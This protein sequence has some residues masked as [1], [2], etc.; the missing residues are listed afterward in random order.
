MSCFLI[1]PN[2]LFKK[3]YLIKKND[4][5]I[6]FI[7]EHPIFYGFRS[8]KMIFN[9]KKLLLHRASIQYYSDYLTSLQIKNKIIDFNNINNFD[10][11]DE[12]DCINF[13]EPEDHMLKSDIM[14]YISSNNKNFNVYHNKLFLNS[15]QDLY[16]YQN[17]TNSKNS[18]FHK[19]FYDWQLKKHKIPYID[20]SY[21]ELNRNKLPDNINFPNYN[22]KFSS[23]REEYL[24]SSKIYLEKYF[25]DN[26]GNYDDFIF[27]INHKDSEKFFKKFLEERLLNFGTYQDAIFKQN[28]LLFHSLISSLINIGLLTPDYII[29]KTVKY[30]KDNK[31]EIKINNFEDLLDKLL[32]GES[33]KECFIIFT[34]MN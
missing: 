14:R 7:I 21:D 27:P 15:L 32:D 8:S 24:S 12:F 2:T 19:T 28:Q 25:S 4:K 20:K 23:D 3:K 13:Y 1:F 34:M 17:D 16:D 30:Y 5:D 22:F 31:S 9:K 26:Y 18:F 33:M 6:H 10:F 29:K 11:L